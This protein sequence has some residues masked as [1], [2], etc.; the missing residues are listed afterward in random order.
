MD[1][2]AQ[3]AQIRTS[4][5]THTALLKDEWRESVLHPHRPNAG[6]CVFLL[7]VRSMYA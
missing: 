6:T 4:A 2:K 3:P 7:R 5:S 1:F